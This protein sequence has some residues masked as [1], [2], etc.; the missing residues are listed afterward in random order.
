[1]AQDWH[2]EIYAG[3]SLPVPYYAG[4]FRDS[5]PT[6]PELIGYDVEVA[7]FPG[8]DHRIV[9]A[10]VSAFVVAVANVFAQLDAM[11]HPGA[12]PTSG[13]ALNGVRRLAAYAH[14]EWVR[15]HPFANGNG[16][17]ARCWANFVLLR[18][19]MPALVSIKPRPAGMLY[20]QAAAASM[21]GNHSPTETFIAG[22][23]QAALPGP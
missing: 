18:Y 19:G 4:E 12:P 3:V 21:L 8:V 9:P 20:A 11:V 15:I 22:L 1:M 10:A 13:V 17:T 5:D 2:R 23:L 7:G 6:F 16:R 14:G